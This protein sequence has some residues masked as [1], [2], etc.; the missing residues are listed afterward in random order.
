MTLQDRCEGSVETAPLRNMD[1]QELRPGEEEEWDQFV[2][3]S[4]AGTF[5]TLA[6][7]KRVIEKVLH[8]RCFY[9][10][11]RNDRGIRG[12]FPISWVRSRLFG[13]CLVSLPLAVYGGICADDREAY[14]NLLQAG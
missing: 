4:P 9:L 14:F 11:A 6:E 5:F 7:G 10:T 8:R 12:V 13:D 3:A 2:A 1:I